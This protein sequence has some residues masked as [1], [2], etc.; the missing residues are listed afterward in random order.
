KWFG[1]AF[2]ELEMSAS[3]LPFLKRA[4]S[5]GSFSECEDY[6]VIAYETIADQ[7][8]A[9]ALADPVDPKTRSFH[10]RPFRVIGG[11]R[12]SQVLREEIA[13]PAVRALPLTGSIDLISDNTD[14][15]ERQ[16]STGWWQD[17]SFLLAE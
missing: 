12:F 1:T 7:Q 6:L 14:V 2:Q 9:L 16:I 3:L 10:D 17:A 4:I 11:E 5:A 13:D 8:N 15:L